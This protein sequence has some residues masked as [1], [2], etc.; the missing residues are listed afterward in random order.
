MLWFSGKKET[1]D[2]F[3]QDCLKRNYDDDD[4][5][6]KEKPADEFLSVCLSI[7]PSVTPSCWK[8]PRGRGIV[9]K[10]Q[11]SRSSSG[12][13]GDSASYSHHP[14][15]REYCIAI[16]NNG[17][18]LES[19]R[20]ES[21]TAQWMSLVSLPHKNRKQ[22]DGKLTMREGSREKRVYMYNK[23]KWSTPYMDQRSSFFHHHIRLISP[24]NFQS[25]Y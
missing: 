7:C 13:T 14:K 2:E 9:M 1:L 11:V 20:T 16:Y 4:V 6:L 15:Q 12:T 10:S 22:S 21:D 24:S 5:I 17:G 19:G 3:P 25:T 8:I 18:R 23:V